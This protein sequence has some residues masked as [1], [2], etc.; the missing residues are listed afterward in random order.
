MIEVKAL[1]DPNYEPQRGQ[2]LT[3]TDLV[4][5]LI[6]PDGRRFEQRAYLVQELATGGALLCT[7]SGRK[8]DEIATNLMEGSVTDVIGCIA[9]WV[10]TGRP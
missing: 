5:T 7:W 4:G 9:T 10:E 2:N 1:L 6:T 3:Y 8:G